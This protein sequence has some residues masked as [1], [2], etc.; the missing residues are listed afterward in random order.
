MEANTNEIQKYIDLI[1][2]K[3]GLPCSV[4]FDGLLAV[5]KFNHQIIYTSAGGFADTRIK[6]VEALL[7]GMAMGIMTG[8]GIGRL[9]IESYY[10]KRN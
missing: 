7:A 3:T 2:E 4:H 10:S 9:K 1:V 8:L 6:S 5:V